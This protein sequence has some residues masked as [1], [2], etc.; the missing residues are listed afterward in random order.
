M[1]WWIKVRRAHAVLPVALAAYGLLLLVGNTTTSVP[2]IS[3][4]SIVQARVVLLAPIPLTTGLFFC[5]ESRLL[6]QEKTAVQPVRLLD[7]LLIF[8]AVGASVLL[9]ALFGFASGSG[10]IAAAGRNTLF[11]TG[12]LLILRPVIHQGA[13]VVPMAWLI[14]VLLMGYRSPQDP[15]PWTVLPEPM[16]APH[17]AASAAAVFAA[18]MFIQFFFRPKRVL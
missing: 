15:Y 14:L 13:A 9:A 16:G 17:A 12:L 11:L 4:G 2:S 5:L 10:D 1:N 8:T 7:A 3:L 18:G 6:H